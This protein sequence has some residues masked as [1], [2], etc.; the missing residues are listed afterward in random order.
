MAC[1]GAGGICLAVTDSLQQRPRPLPVP[2]LFP[3]C[4]L[5]VPCLPAAWGAGCGHSGSRAGTV[6][7]WFMSPAEIWGK[8]K[9]S[10]GL[11]SNPAARVQ[12]P[13]VGAE[14]HR[15]AGAWGHG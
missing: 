10:G 8:T 3:A 9:R 15:D 14:C 4:P 5:P 2:S 6:L 7:S 11:G 12:I 13:S 1:C